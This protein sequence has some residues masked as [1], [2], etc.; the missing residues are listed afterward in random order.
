MDNVRDIVRRFILEDIAGG[1]P[2]CAAFADDTQLRASGI[3]DSLSLLK[4]IAFLEDR[5]DL[6]MEAADLGGDQLSSLVA[7]EHLV[8]S[9]SARLP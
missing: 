6:R 1:G 9:R 7:I 8:R 2:G 4:L 5:F 3:I